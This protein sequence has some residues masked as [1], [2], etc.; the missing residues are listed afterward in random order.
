MVLLVSDRGRITN[1]A[2]GGQEPE[3]KRSPTSNRARVKTGGG[4]FSGCNPISW[5][6]SG[7]VY[8]LSVE[9][10]VTFGTVFVA[11]HTWSII[12]RHS[13]APLPLKGSAEA[14][15]PP[16]V[17]GLLTPENRPNCCS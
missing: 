5:I 13:V 12:E 3:K 2:I 1:F 8:R 14:L 6:Q 7:H 11:L 9:S 10:I 4:N 16:G 17:F 15:G